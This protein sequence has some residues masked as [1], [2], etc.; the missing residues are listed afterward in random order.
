MY[1]KNASLA[2]SQ[3]RSISNAFLSYPIHHTNSISD[4]RIRRKCHL[5]G[6]VGLWHLCGISITKWQTD[7]WANT[8]RMRL[9]VNRVCEYVRSQEE[10]RTRKKKYR[11]RRRKRRRRIKMCKRALFLWRK[12]IW[13]LTAPFIGRQYT[14]VSVWMRGARYDNSIGV[15]SVAHK[16]PC[17]ASGMS[18]T[19]GE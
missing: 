1:D 5:M 9:Y 12:P 8:Y 10:L 14:F 17:N 6:L 7:G 18:S 19:Y 3:R 2:Y 4:H 15:V 16:T 13:N 11:G